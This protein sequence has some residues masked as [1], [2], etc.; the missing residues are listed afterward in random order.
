MYRLLD[1]TTYIDPWRS[2]I[3]KVEYQA[4]IEL[5]DNGMCDQDKMHVRRPKSSLSELASESLSSG[6][7]RMNRANVLGQSYSTKHTHLPGTGME[8]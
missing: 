6:Q 4:M 1:S 8:V 5:P 2:K 7:T 3:N